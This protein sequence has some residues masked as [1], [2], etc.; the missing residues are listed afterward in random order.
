MG[1]KRNQ[2]HLLINKKL[3]IRFAIFV[4]GLVTASLCMVWGS[5]EIVMRILLDHYR[6]DPIT[7]DILKDIHFYML[8]FFFWEGLLALIVSSLLTLF[9]S[10]RVV[11]PIYR[12]QEEINYFLDNR[13]NSDFEEREIRIRTNDAFQDLNQ[14]VNRL[15]EEVQKNR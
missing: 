10:R 4:A 15:I 6:N 12:I 2:L 8:Y 14:L 5:M 1:Q 11:G 7:V 13:Q 3:Q 9:L